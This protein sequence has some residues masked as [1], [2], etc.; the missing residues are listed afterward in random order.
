[1]LLLGAMVVIASLTGVRAQPIDLAAR[2]S[3]S[4]EATTRSA[5][6]AT[7]ACATLDSVFDG[8]ITIV[9]PSPVAFDADRLPDLL[10]GTW[11][12]DH[13]A[14]ERIE[15]VLDLSSPSASSG[16]VARLYDGRTDLAG[17][18]DCCTR[19]DLRALDATVSVRAPDGW[20]NADGSWSTDLVIDV[21]GPVEVI[22]GGSAKLSGDLATDGHVDYTIEVT[23]LDDDG[24]PE[25]DVRRAHV[26]DAVARR[27]FRS[28]QAIE[29]SAITVN[30]H[31][32]EER[33][34]SWIPWPFLG[35]VTYG[36]LTNSDLAD[37]YPPIQIDWEAGRIVTV[38]EFVRS[39]GNDGQWFVY[40]FD[41]L[42]SGAT[43]NELE[44][45]SPFAF[46][47]LFDADIELPELAVRMTY[48]S[49]GSPTLY[50]GGYPY[51]VSGVRYSWIQ[52]QQDRFRQYKVG[53]LDRYPQDDVVQ[54][55]P[56]ALRAFAPYATLPVWVTQ[57]SWTGATFVAE[58]RPQDTPRG[59]GEGLNAW[60][61]DTFSRSAFFS[62]V[63]GLGAS[64]K[65]ATAGADEIP[66]GLRGEYR[67]GMTAE[68]MLYRSPIDD[69][70]HLLHAGGGVWSQGQGD[71]MTYGN[72]NGDA[73]IDVWTL[74]ERRPAS[75]YGSA[76]SLD[77]GADGALPAAR[78][79]LY[80]LPGHLVRWD[81]GGLA[82]KRVATRHETLRAPPPA[83]SLTWSA[84]AERLA[85]GD[86][87]PARTT[88]PMFDRFE[89]DQALLRGA[90]LLDATHLGSERGYAFLVELASIPA[91]SAP[92]LPLPLEG[93]RYVFGLAADG[94][95]WQVEPYR[96]GTLH[97][98]LETS[99]PTR[100]E[101]TRARLVASSD[102][103]WPTKA[104]A[105]LVVGDQPVRRWDPLEIPA[106]GRPAT[107]RAFTWSPLAS[108]L[109]DVTLVD[110]DG[111]VLARLGTIVVAEAAPG[112]D[113]SDVASAVLPRPGAFVALLAAAVLLLA[114]GVN[115]AV[116]RRAS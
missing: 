34:R 65:D 100:L 74:L 50:A 109:Q 77:E 62:H 46:Y 30:P 7:Y 76:T 4:C 58:M 14:D 64:A 101:P 96:A 59:L 78:E 68:P 45:E 13:G 55:G 38:G 20:R 83:T 88:A 29:R 52:R 89:G 44:F 48:T 11:L 113:R 97:A 91:V 33:I 25:Y 108:G 54:V 32:D 49:P 95:T 73:Y 26:P 99:A 15:V 40:S 51:P 75:A 72:L 105:T 94:A 66:E 98:R 42:G 27:I 60:D 81:A 82:I 10:E 110:D 6:R 70:L 24:R 23:D 111:V 3:L 92:W 22:F 79:R 36:F 18:E 115:R 56:Y 61:V 69:E 21:D 47:D 93:G 53:L 28:G 63:L 90:T 1:M 102:G 85:D 107:E 16:A 39:R 5:T 80:Q 71:V 114:V 8:A 84:L 103:P 37:N 106:A 104:H 43:P 2:A 87:A 9:S 86:R 19:D 112:P 35:P 67:L 41:E 116:G 57:R 12:F 31:H 17:A